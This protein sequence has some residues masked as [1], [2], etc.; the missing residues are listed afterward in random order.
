M[1]KLILV[2]LFSSSLFSYS[3]TK[4]LIYFKDKGTTVPGLLNKTSSMLAEASSLLSTRSIMRREKV[5]KNGKI[6]TFE[7]LP[8]DQ[9]Y[10]NKIESYGIKI[11]NKLN[12]FNAVSA[13]LTDE[14]INALISLPFVS[15]ITPVKTFVSP[16][17]QSDNIA[18]QKIFAPSPSSNYGFSLNQL[19]FSDIPIVQSKGITG[20]GVMVGILDDGFYW[21]EQASLKTRKVLAEYNYVFHTVSTEQQPGDDPTSGEHGTLVFSVIGGYKDSSMIGVAYNATFVLAKT[22]DDRSESHIEEDNYA[23]ALQ[24]MDSLGVDITTSSLG[25]NI[26]DDTT[27]SY[28]Y[29][30]MNGNTTIITK[31]AELAY[32][33]GILVLTAAGNEGDNSWHYIV[34]PADGFHVIAVGAVDLGNNVAPFSSRGPTYDGRIKPDVVADG[35]NVYGANYVPSFPNPNAYYYESGTSLSTPIASGIAALLYSAFPYLT[36][37]QA[38]YILMQTADNSANPNNDRGY[39]LVSALKAI[40]YPNIFFNNSNKTYSINKI[41]IVQNGVVPSSAKI[42][43]SFDGNNFSTSNL[44]FDGSLKYSFQIP[45]ISNNQSIFFY[46]TYNDSAGTNMRDPASNFYSLNYGALNISFVKI[47]T[48][49]LETDVLS[50][51]FPNPF[52]PLNGFTTIAFYSSSNVEAKLTIF[53]SIGQIVRVLSKRANEGSNFFFWDGKN[54]K[55]KLCASGVYLYILSLNGKNY[56]NKLILLK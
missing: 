39:G 53:N 17:Y 52:N 22:E 28:T 45:V 37:D 30:D 48:S 44:S 56:G 35:V 42:H 9:N 41:F 31:A 23:A 34:A 8:L 12:W 14:Q 6:L 27:Y 24:W 15:K 29:A 55:G 3:Q 49:N 21:K 7:D 1:K 33:R 20:S 19:D 5:M 43:Y 2:L 13:Y 11:E 16:K 51:N 25:Y 26:F 18:T 4:Y 54:N 40:S 46:Y 47:Q 38:R 10:I 32:Q 36:N 50:N